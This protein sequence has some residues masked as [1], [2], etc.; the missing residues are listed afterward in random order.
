M[1]HSAQMTLSVAML[2]Q[3]PEV[4]I[5]ILNVIMLNVVIMSV[6]MPSVVAPL[7]HFAA[8]DQ[9]IFFHKPGPCPA[10]PFVL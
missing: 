2:F 10:K 4:F 6:V 5:I 3:Y 9:A 7:R 1:G 8:T